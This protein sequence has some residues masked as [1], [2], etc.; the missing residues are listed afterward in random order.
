MNKD[1]SRVLYKLE[2]EALY[3]KENESKIPHDERM[4]AITQQ[5]ALF[6][7]ILLKSTGANN[8]LEIGTSVGFSTIWF[9]EAVMANGGGRIITIEHDAKKVKRAQKNFQEAKVLDIITIKNKTALEAIKEIKE[10]DN[11]KFDFVF[12]DA[13]K[14]GV[15]EYFDTIL[16]LVKKHGIIVT[17]NIIYPEKFREIMSKFVK[18]IKKKSN[19]QTITVPIGNG[20]EISLKRNDH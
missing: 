20:E 16:P 11:T 6:L 5:T 14:E 15:R 7:N 17:D 4:L 19:I 10:K 2:K 12:I 8:I 3:E 9:A 13:D 1:I 18:H